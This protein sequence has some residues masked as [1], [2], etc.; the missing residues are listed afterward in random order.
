ML[1]LFKRLIQ[2]SSLDRDPATQQRIDQQ[3]SR[4][5]LY[6]FTSCPYCVRV[7][8]ALHRLRLTLETRD[9]SRSPHRE[10]LVAGGRLYQV[11]CLRITRDDGSYEWLYGSED[12][13]AWLRSRFVNR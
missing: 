13:I 2:P 1:S 10:E 7:R 4:L 5:L 6:Q 12:I 3:T 9:A 11:P 8:L